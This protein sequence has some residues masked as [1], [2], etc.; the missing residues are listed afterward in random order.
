MKNI[1]KAR[2]FT[3]AFHI[4]SHCTHCPAKRRSCKDIQNQ[5]SECILRVINYFDKIAKETLLKN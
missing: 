5:S 1:I 2:E 4:A 3:M